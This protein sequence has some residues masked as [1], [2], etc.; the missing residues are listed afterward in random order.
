MEILYYYHDVFAENSCRKINGGERQKYA[1]KIYLVVR[2]PTLLLFPLATR[3]FLLPA[4]DYGNV[5]GEPDR[6]EIVVGNG[7]RWMMVQMRIG[8]FGL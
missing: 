5:F 6:S 3:D 4:R 2:P 1:Q 7:E 8:R